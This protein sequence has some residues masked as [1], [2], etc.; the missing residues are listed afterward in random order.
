MAVTLR[1]LRYLVALAETGGFGAAA[2]AVHVTQPALSQQIAELERLLGVRLVDRLPRGSRLT[3][4]GEAV[5]RRARGVLAGIADLEALAREADGLSGRILLGMIPTVAPYLLPD[6]LE[7]LAAHPI[8][9]R[10]REAQTADLLQAV[11]AGALDAAVVA[12]P[13]RGPLAALPLGEDRFV[14]A[15]PPGRLAALQAERLRPSAIAGEPLLLLDEGHCLADQAL[16]VCGLRSRPPA[17]L[18]ASSLGTLC[19]LVAGGYGLTLLPEIAVPTEARAGLC[20]AR[21]AAPEPA[22]TLCLAVRD[23]AGRWAA[24]LATRLTEALEA[25]RSRARAQIA[26]ATSQAV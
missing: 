13:V 16:E 8:E 26:E 7:R 5:L 17:D 12:S 22:R 25:R 23:G 4:A 2:R 3:R 1:H 11:E 10:L 21:F 14:L 24:D 19:G 15:A 6:L 20:L 18:G 9:L